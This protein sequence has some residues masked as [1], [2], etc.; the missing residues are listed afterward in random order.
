MRDTWV[1]PRSDEVARKVI[2]ADDVKLR[3]DPVFCEEI[4][5]DLGNPASE[6]QCCPV[7]SAQPQLVHYVL[8]VPRVNV[9]KKRLSD[10]TKRPPTLPQ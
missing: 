8:C 9:W 2:E 1:S 7:Q 4:A 5:P 3:R 6:V 10:P